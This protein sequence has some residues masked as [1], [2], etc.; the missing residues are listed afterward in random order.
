MENC[1]TFIHDSIFCQFVLSG[2]CI[3]NLYY[4]KCVGNSTDFLPLPYST[5]LQF[6]WFEFLILLCKP[7]QERANIPLI[8]TEYP[9]GSKEGGLFFEEGEKLYIATIPSESCSILRNPSP[10]RKRKGIKRH[11]SE[12]KGLNTSPPDKKKSPLL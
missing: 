6:I 12:T 4:V 9:E 5:A 8:I 2:N 1:F 7:L 3:D 10:N 11:P